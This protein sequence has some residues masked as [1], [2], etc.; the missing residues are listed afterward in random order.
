MLILYVTIAAL[1]LVRTLPK[2]ATLWDSMSR[3]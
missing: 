1:V 2:M 3:Y